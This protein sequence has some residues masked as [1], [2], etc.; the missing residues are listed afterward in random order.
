MSL[1]KQY[2][3]IDPSP[4]SLQDLEQ[5]YI[6]ISTLLTYLQITVIQKSQ[7][8]ICWSDVKETFGSVIHLYMFT[9]C[10]VIRM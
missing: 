5:G 4:G 9:N 8:L 1:M 10:Y 7:L 6:S 3:Q 2:K